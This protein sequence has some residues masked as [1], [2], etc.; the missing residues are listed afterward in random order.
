MKRTSPKVQVSDLAPGLWIWRLEHPGWN[1]AVDW[2]E[3][4]TCVCVDAGS[5]RWLLDPLLPPEDAHHVWDRFSQRAPTAV[6]ILKADH[7]RETWSDRGTWSVDALVPRY[8]CRAFGP[9]IFDTQ[10][11]P[12]T[13]LKKNCAQPAP[14]WRALRPS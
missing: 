10:P 14:T 13:A 1:D 12:A 7:N 8:D 2:Q 4:V 5:E 9:A 3:V 11:A 6:A